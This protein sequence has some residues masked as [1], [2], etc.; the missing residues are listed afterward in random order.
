MVCSPSKSSHDKNAIENKIKQNISRNLTLIKKQKETWVRF[1][2]A[3]CRLNI[4]DVNKKI[5]KISGY[6][7]IFSMII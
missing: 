7:F 2:N 6:I 1:E 5:E 3:D 4:I